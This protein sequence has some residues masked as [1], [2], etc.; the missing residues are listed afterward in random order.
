MDTLRHTIVIG[1]GIVGICCA[2]ALRKRGLQVTVVDRLEPGQGCSFGNAGILAAQAVVPIGLPG[3]ARQLPRMLFDGSHPLTLR[4]GSL[5]RCLPWLWRLQQAS[6]IER[7][8]RIA[9]AMK[10]LYGSTLERHQALAQEAG[11][12]ELVRPTPGLYVHRRA[13]AIDVEQGLA[14]RL[15]HERGAEIELLEGA[16]LR[17][18]E[19]AL[20]NEFVRGARMGAMGITLNPH[21]LVQAYAALLQRLGG[22]IVRAQVNALEPGADGVRLRGSAELPPADAVVVAAGAWSATLLQPL[23]LKLPLIAERGYHLTYT[24]SGIRLK[25]VVTD[26]EA[27]FAVTDMEMGLRVA[28]T[29]ELGDADDAPDWRRAE[30]LQRHAQRLFPT[31]RLQQSSR[32]MGPRPGLPDS[33]P[34]IGAVPGQPR[35]F[36]ATGHGH[37]GLTGGPHTGQWVAELVSGAQ[38]SLPLD[39][40]APG[41]FGG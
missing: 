41:R 14:W 23:G 37:L 12:S 10:A 31:A 35:I 15:R 4:P 24:D 40:Y 9:D 3:L 18:A 25:H 30:V 16:A 29:E 38:P 32:W 39:A 19:P 36:V 11:V 27:H 5:P 21:R 13:S 22:K 17:E 6:R 33:L 28:G 8:K 20:S 34:A 2:I 1:A 26:I 7:V